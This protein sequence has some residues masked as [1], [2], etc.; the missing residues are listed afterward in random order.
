MANMCPAIPTVVADMRPSIPAVV[1][2]M[3]AAIDAA[4]MMADANAAAPYD[5]PAPPVPPNGTAPTQA[6]AP[7]IATPIPAGSPPA[8][9]IP[10]IVVTAVN[11]CGFFQRRSHL[12]VSGKDAVADCCF[13]R[14]TT[15]QRR[16]GNER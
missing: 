3:A 15:R 6:V 4:M 11:I 8:L 9:F 7:G 14:T 13:G 12:D 5:T 10:T 16:G 1:A 2:N